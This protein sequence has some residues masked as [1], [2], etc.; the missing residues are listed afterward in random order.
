[1]AFDI[2]KKTVFLVIPNHIFA[3]DLLRTDYIKYLSDIYNIVVV[4][5][6]IGSKEADNFGYFN[7]GNILYIKRNLDH[8][9]FWNVFK[10]LRITLVNKFDYLNYF[11]Q[12]YLRD[13]FKKNRKR[14]LVRFLGKPFK[15]IL[16]ADFFTAL[17]KFLMPIPKDIADIFVRFNP[18]LIITSTP[19]LNPFEAELIISA[20]KNGI[21]T[22]AID[23][24]WDNLTTNAK[25]MRKTDYLIAWNSIMKKEA[26]DIHKYLQEKVFVS[27]PMRFDSY[28]KNEKIEP[29]RDEFLKSKGL[30][31]NNKTIFYT[32]VTK[33]YPFQKRYLKELL[34]LRESGGIPYVNVFVRIHP[35][36]E[37]D[38]YKEFFDCKDFYFEKAGNEAADEN[39]NK[40]IEMRQEDFL[41]LKYSLKYTDININYASTIS[42]EACVFNKPII[43]IGYIGIYGM[44]YNFNHYEPVYKS[45]AVMLA[46]TERELGDY[47]NIYL[48]NPD[49]DSENR[50]K[51]FDSFFDFK[52]GLSYKRS[53]D[54]LDKIIK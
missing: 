17:E 20:R 52:D 4:S 24:S 33:A 43:N 32:T 15:N 49:K 10:F 42:I 26:V 41:N 39:G 23:F 50:K 40:N 37:Y 13:N 51:V 38:N 29:T 9:R 31:P 27:G 47:I 18:T 44:A 2:N 12:F 45:G 1:M 48:K 14:R 28:F 36:D 25:H 46:K 3:S 7:S 5:P 54:F 22:V 35:R 53:A 34:N 16:T 30:N 6:I 11:K 21:P 19:G 8:S